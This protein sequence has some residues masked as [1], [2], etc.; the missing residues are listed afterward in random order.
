MLKV[1]IKSKYGSL[2]LPS[3]KMSRMH[4]CMKSSSNFYTDFISD[5]D[6]RVYTLSGLQRVQVIIYIAYEMHTFS[7]E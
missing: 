7:G 6:L 4:T 2:S 3:L 5:V 1:F